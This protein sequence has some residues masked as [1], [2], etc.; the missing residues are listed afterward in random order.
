MDGVKEE[1]TNKKFWMIYFPD[2]DTLA[3]KGVDGIVPKDGDSI[4]YKYEHYCTQD[5]DNWQAM[6]ER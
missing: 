2:C 5:S 3:K 6:I 4:V 1:V